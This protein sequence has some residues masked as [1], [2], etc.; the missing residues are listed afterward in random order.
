ME[1][2]QGEIELLEV[3]TGVSA[4][5]NAYRRGVFTI[6]KLKYSTFDQKIIDGFKPGDVVEMEGEQQGPYWNM[7]TMIKIS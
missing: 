7:K 6:N 5:G 2:K 1:K 3:K 4:T